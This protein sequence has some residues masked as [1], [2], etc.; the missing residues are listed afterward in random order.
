M[1]YHHASCLQVAGRLDDFQEAVESISESAN[2][3]T[4]AINLFSRKKPAH[5]AQDS[6]TITSSR[7]LHS[8]H[9]PQ[10]R[11]EVI[12]CDIVVGQL[13]HSDR[14]RPAGPSSV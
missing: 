6:R 10:I 9:T 5:K 7:G 11:G 14:R 1:F 13:E 4:K 2:Q 12:V 3:Y 8:P